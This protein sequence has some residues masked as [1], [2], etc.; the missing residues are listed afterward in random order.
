MKILINSIKPAVII[1]LFVSLPS[2]LFAG[3]DCS[4][5]NVESIKKEKGVTEI[6]VK[7]IDKDNM[8]LMKGCPRFNF[9]VTYKRV[10]WY[11]RLPFMQS[12]HPTEKE[13]KES[14]N[15]M[16]NAYKSKK[17][18]NF[19]YMGYGLAHTEKE[20]SFV[21]YGLKTLQIQG[22]KLVVSFYN[23]I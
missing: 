12:S 17:V 20:C 7:Q 1:F 5:M 16:E 11:S 8:L 21:S 19:C 2:M 22:N 6:E 18:I 13:N 14:L 23:E 9:T 15:L 10:P 3:G 4:L